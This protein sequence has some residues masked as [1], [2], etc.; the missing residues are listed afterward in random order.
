M[1]K[2]LP[3]KGQESS[4]YII[5]PDSYDSIVIF[6]STISGFTHLFSVIKNYENV[7][8]FMT[9]CTMNNCIGV[10][11]IISYCLA[12]NIKTELFAVRDI[13]IYIRKHFDPKLLSKISFKEYDIPI[14][15]EVKDILYQFIF[16]NSKYDKSRSYI[17]IKKRNKD[18]T[19]KKYVYTGSVELVNLSLLSEECC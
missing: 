18:S 11:N 16:K 4:I 1:I 12:L 8:L 19:F 10:Q 17:L 2:I 7:F 9:E 6:N 15:I 13:A 3:S 5:E 14:D